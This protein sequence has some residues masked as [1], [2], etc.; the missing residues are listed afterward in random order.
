MCAHCGSVS[1]CWASDCLFCVRLVRACG[2]QVLLRWLNWHLEQ[3][4]RP[5]RVRNFGKDVS[6]SVAY[7]I[8]LSRIAPK[9]AGATL[10][11]LAVQD[12][13][14]RAQSVV[15][16]AKK[17]GEVSF[18]IT[19]LDIVGGNEKLNL[20]FVAA[21]FN[22]APG[23][24]LISAETA[25]RLRLLASQ[26]QEQAMEEDAAISAEESREERAFRMWINSLGLAK[27]VTNLFHDCKDAMA[28]LQ[29]R[30][31]ACSWAR[32]LEHGACLCSSEWDGC[33]QRDADSLQGRQLAR[34]CSP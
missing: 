12:P 25:E 32:G 19:A 31:A 26:R 10:A 34:A 11:P 4:G 8:L 21:L 20:A 22:A 3:A 5:E 2:L 24:D 28:I 15:V 6:D 18:A 9:E 14:A 29:V 27:F 30:A 13:V 17:I 7:T 16:T 33:C 1:V 23:L